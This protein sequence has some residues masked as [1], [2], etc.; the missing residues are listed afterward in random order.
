VRFPSPNAKLASIDPAWFDEAE[1]VILDSEWAGVV[2]RPFTIQ[3]FQL[4]AN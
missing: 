4:P 3:Q 1:L 2:T